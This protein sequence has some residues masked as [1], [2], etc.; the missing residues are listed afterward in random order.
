MQDASTAASTAQA[1]Y[2]EA[3]LECLS[4]HAA[5]Q[6]SRAQVAQLE[7][8]IFRQLLAD[9]QKLVRVK[10]HIFWCFPWYLL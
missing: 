10:A 4:L 3:C 6:K 5:V 2:A 1:P 9:D 8:V 7:Q